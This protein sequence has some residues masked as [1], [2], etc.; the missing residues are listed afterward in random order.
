MPVIPT[1]T[2]RGEAT[3]SPTAAPVLHTTPNSRSDL[4][5]GIIVLVVGLIC[6]GLWIHGV[7]YP[8]WKSVRAA[9]A[10]RKNVV[11]DLEAILGTSH[12]PAR[13]V[14]PPQELQQISPR[15]M[16]QA[17]PTRLQ[18]IPE[19]ATPESKRSQT[20]TLVNSTNSHKPNSNFS[21]SNTSDKSDRSD[22]SFSSARSQADSEPFPEFDPE[23]HPSND[24]ADFSLV[25]LQSSVRDSQLSDST[26]GTTVE[27]GEAV[28]VRITMHSPVLHSPR[29]GSNV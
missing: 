14:E 16:S 12:E 3:P 15:P 7:G 19:T 20:T 27:V 18:S 8:W 26:M 6:V 28:E 11:T 9:R 25:G 10:V 21:P 5:A 1:F 23:Y 4:I 24:L 2:L 13:E 29:R 22:D 17:L